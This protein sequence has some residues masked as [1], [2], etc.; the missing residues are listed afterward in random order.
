MLHEFSVEVSLKE[1]EDIMEKLTAHHYSNLY[2]NQPIKSFI[3]PHGYGFVEQKEEAVDVH[4]YLECCENIEAEKEKIAAILEVPKNQIRYE[5]MEEKDWQQAFSTIELGNGWFIQP[6]TVEEEVNG[7][8]ITFEPPRAFGSGLHGTTQDCLR[9]ILRED[10]TGKKVLDL[11]AGAGLLSI[12]AALKGAENVEAVDIED[13]ETEVL[14]NAGLNGVEDRIYVLQGDVLDPIFKLEATYDWIFVNIG[15]Y[16][17]TMLR[18]F[19]LEHLA[20][21]SKLL[22]SGLVEWNA[23]DVLG[24][25]DTCNVIE[26]KQSEEWVTALLQKG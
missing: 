13:V 4:I 12:A 26:V 20:Q 1:I 16:E 24:L 8:V 10:F 9:F 19:I 23:N 6:P 18:P 17:L 21:G 11:G 22:V 14:Y 15:G 7:Q 25:Y 2:Y 3:E 5:Y